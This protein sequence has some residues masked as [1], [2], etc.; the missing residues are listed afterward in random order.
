M[1]AA[2]HGQ[3]LWLPR[4]RPL[5]LATLTLLAEAAQQFAPVRLGFEGVERAF[6][7]GDLHADIHCA[8]FWV[9]RSGLVDVDAWNWTGEPN[10]AL[11]FLGD[12]VDKGPHGRQV[13]E[14]VRNLTEAWPD[15]V[16]ALLGN[17]DLYFLSDALFSDG[18]TQLM[19][20]PV[21]QFVYAFTHPEEYLNWLPEQLRNDSST[22]EALHALFQALQF[23][24][25]HRD[26]ARVMLGHVR[27]RK[28]L[29]AS[30]P[31]F[32]KDRQL[33]KSVQKQLRTWRRHLVEGLTASGLADWLAARPVVAVVGGALVVHGGLPAADLATVASRRHEHETLVQALDAATTGA[34]RQLW[35]RPQDGGAAD[36]GRLEWGLENAELIHEAVTF[37]GYHGGRHG[38]ANPCGEVESV[39][40]LLRPETG[41][42]L[43]VVGHT[44]GDSV[45]LS[46]GRKLVAADSSLSRYF[47]AF[48]NLYCPVGTEV[49]RP[50]SSGCDAP[51]SE[52]CEGHASRLFRTN[53]GWRLE[54]VP[55]GHAGDS[56]TAAGRNEF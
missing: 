13:L 6:I 20:S 56:S 4:W 10:D 33:A 41:V 46:C 30:V 45:R 12:Y 42:E 21:H 22:H 19:G 24:Y 2:M 53:S 55:A 31:P 43:I 29:F 8:E 17:H 3:Y 5:L 36:F 49:G 40:K 28:D 18:A 26:E 47:R 9:R 38:G 50:S 35:Q 34:F 54:P 37:R 48:G 39:L 14:F 25:S 44:P 11:V 23:V 52:T 32:N 16:L 7:I 51:I 15:N 27:G 1:A